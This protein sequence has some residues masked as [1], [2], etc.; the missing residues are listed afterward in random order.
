MDMR[1]DED[2]IEQTLVWIQQKIYKGIFAV[3]VWTLK[4]GSSCSIVPEDIIWSKNQ[5]IVNGE[6]ENTILIK[7][8]VD[9][10]RPAKKAVIEFKD[11]STLIFWG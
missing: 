9:D 1:L 4:N 5:F 10:A 2:E 3:A 11:G 8:S 6:N 7:S